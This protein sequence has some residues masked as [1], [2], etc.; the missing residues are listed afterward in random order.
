MQ[1]HIE[2]N[3]LQV[4]RT[5]RKEVMNLISFG[6][7]PR[8]ALCGLFE[9]ALDDCH[10]EFLHD[11]MVCLKDI[12]QSWPDG[13]GCRVFPVPATRGDRDEDAAQDAYTDLPHWEDEQLVL[14]L[15]LLD[16]IIEQLEETTNASK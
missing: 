11:S 3:L 5:I 12:M 7:E 16:Y 1:T 14:R 10:G 6:G 9:N 4:A 8:S 13:T 15:E 2:R